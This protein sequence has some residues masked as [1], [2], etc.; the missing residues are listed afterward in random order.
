MTRSIRD[1]SG[2]GRAPS[3]IARDRRQQVEAGGGAFVKRPIFR[4]DRRQHAA[5]ARVLR[6]GGKAVG[7]QTPA[8]ERQVLLRQRA[9]EAGA[10]AGGDDE[11]VNRSHVVS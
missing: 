3:W 1:R 6:E 5:D 10:P 8:A 2:K 9:A 4:P 7:E 11:S